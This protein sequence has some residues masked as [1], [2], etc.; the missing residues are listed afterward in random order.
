M[1]GKQAAE[2][3]SVTRDV[4]SKEE[5]REVEKN[6]LQL[7][8]EELTKARE[9][10]KQLAQDLAATSTSF[11]EAEDMAAAQEKAVTLPHAYN[12][13]LLEQAKEQWRTGKWGAL[14]SLDSKG[15]E[16]HPDRAKLALLI[17]A[18]YQQENDFVA[19]RHWLRLSKEWGC[20]KRL[21]AKVLLASAYNTLGRIAVINQN[22]HKAD[23]CFQESIT[24][25]GLKKRTGAR[26]QISKTIVDINEEISAS[27]NVQRPIVR[28][29]HHFACTGGTL[30]TKCIAALPD[31]VVLN[32][33]DP[34][35]TLGL[36]LSAKPAF[37]PRDI[38]SLMRQ[39]G[40]NFDEKAI[41]DIFCNDIATIVDNMTKQDKFL[42]LREHMHS[43]Y[44]TGDTV[45]KTTT[46]RNLLSSS[47]DVRSVVT[48]RDPIDSYLSLLTQGWLHFSPAT[49]D[50]YCSRYLKFIEDYKGVTIIR[51]E[52][53]VKEPQMI[54]QD[55]CRLINVGYES[56]F[57]SKFSQY[58]FSG[59][60][61]RT[62]DVI[63]PRERRPYSEE[64]VDEVNNSGSYLEL[65]SLLG[66]LPGL[67][68]SPL[69]KQI[70]S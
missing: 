34:F 29:L 22:D 58:K 8:Q 38:I 13:T 65:C 42:V 33:V 17:A 54:M 60:S 2:D 47:F 36:D 35:S 55:I 23:R 20:E 31:V 6:E 30:F 5:K 48:V 46:L 67:N 51:Y 40:N 7:L 27:F 11:V 57:T 59:D 15:V 28:T 25:G 66:Y 52:D 4:E 50:E 14:V 9:E 3:N 56:D 62:G 44:L 37:E 63:E 16:H 43:G 41:G 64:F 12:E 45:R 18:G 19:T 21:V 1:R 53:F 32:E 49:F 10:N 68:E 26:Q 69:R 61:G 70:I 39:S 24:C